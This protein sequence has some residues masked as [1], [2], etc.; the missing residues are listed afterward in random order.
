MR[1]QIIVVAIVLLASVSA[2]RAAYITYNI[3]DYPLNETD[4]FSNVT[5]TI[6]GTIITDGTL[7]DLWITNIVGG[8][9][10]FEGN[11]LSLTLGPAWASVS[12]ATMIFATQTQ[13]QIPDG[14]AVEIGASVEQDT[15]YNVITLNYVRLKNN[16]PVLPMYWGTALHEQLGLIS[17]FYSE[18]PSSLPGNYTHIRMY[19]MFS[20][21]IVTLNR[22]QGYIE[23]FHAEATCV[24]CNS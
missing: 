19:S 20:F 15:Y 7:G 11:G 6:S 21:V 17:S 4:L 8:T 2:A 16:P 10:T 12:T 5:D 23:S 14:Y 24:W 3:V 22:A 18:G 13:L 1:W 9:L